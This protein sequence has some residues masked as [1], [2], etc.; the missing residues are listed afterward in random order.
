MTEP[1]HPDVALS[2]TLSAICARN[3]YVTDAGPV[4][5]ELRAAAGDRED[6]LAEVSGT[7]AGFNETDTHAGALVT[8]LRS[9]PGTEAWVAVGRTRA[10]RWHVAR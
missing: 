1:L 2:V 3:R 8:A 9:I 4:L 10:G 6:V 7:W 5:A